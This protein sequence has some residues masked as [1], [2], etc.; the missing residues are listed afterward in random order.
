[1]WSMDGRGQTRESWAEL[2]VLVN[3]LSRPPVVVCETTV[4]CC[5]FFYLYSH[6]TSCFQ[7]KLKESERDHSLVRYITHMD[8]GYQQREE[9]SHVC[10]LIRLFHMDILV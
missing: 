7:R 9:C 8:Y 10:C 1:M 3:A 6:E 5:S 2:Y 4:G